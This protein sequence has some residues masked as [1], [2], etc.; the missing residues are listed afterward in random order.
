MSNYRLCRFTMKH[1][2]KQDIPELLLGEPAFCKDTGEM[3]IG[4]GAGK[5]PTRI[6]SVGEEQV[7]ALEEQVNQAIE[8]AK[9]T[10][11]TLETDLVVNGT[12]L[13]SVSINSQGV[14]IKDVNNNV[15]FS[16]DSSFT[17]Y[18]E[19]LKVKN[20]SLSDVAETGIMPVTRGQK[21]KMLTYYVSPTPKG[22]GDGTSRDNAC[23]DFY[24]VADTV[25]KTYGH[26][27]PATKILIWLDPGVYTQDMSMPHFPGNI[28]EV[29]VQTDVNGTSTFTNT[30]GVYTSN[31]SIHFYG[32]NLG[33]IKFQSTNEV[34]GHISGQYPR[35]CA[36]AV[37]GTNVNLE[38]TYCHW[39]TPV[40]SE[41]TKFCIYGTEGARNI[42][43]SFNYCDFYGYDAFLF[44][45]E[46]HGEIIMIDCCGDINDWVHSNAGGFPK[47]S[48][49]LRIYLTGT[50]PYVLYEQ[51]NEYID[52]ILKSRRELKHSSYYKTTTDP[53]GSGEVVQPPVTTETWVNKEDRY[54]I[55]SSGIKVFNWS[56]VFEP[57]YNPS[58]DPSL[59]IPRY[60]GET[61]L[62]DCLSQGSTAVVDSN[63]AEIVHYTV[64]Y[65]T[66]ALNESTLIY[67][68]ELGTKEKTGVITNLT[69]KLVF[70]QQFYHSNVSKPRII[71]PPA[72]IDIPNHMITDNGYYVTQQ[73]ENTSDGRPTYVLELEGNH[74][75][76]TIL[77]N[78][79]FYS[80]SIILN[81][82]GDGIPYYGI[83][84]GSF[85]NEDLGR[86]TVELIISYKEKTKVVG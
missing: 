61:S 52:V 5:E 34:S 51:D 39:V 41:T 10:A 48:L 3:F 30:V 59:A 6:G 67:L 43:Y 74:H 32:N 63:T 73:G 62:N 49:G 79:L 19:T 4:N 42:N 82:A 58:T 38:F 76:A 85:R 27:C 68:H 35:K 9:K 37:Y 66:L 29:Y 15:K 26:L 86:F 24:T 72:G 44:R 40:T 12:K 46:A 1:G 75:L 69:A 2:N 47:T 21:T 7:K 17:T 8:L 77:K 83:Q 20:I 18:A 22:K 78:D 14:S 45:G 60:S 70:T 55:G 13:G 64:D 31:A 16:V 65:G 11:S 53:G 50:Y 36:V 25:F 23:S 84:I 80:D 28:W 57:M 71:Y 33:L 56:A 54:S 81:S